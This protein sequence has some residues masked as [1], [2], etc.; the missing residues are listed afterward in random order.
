MSLCHLATLLTVEDLSK[1]HDILIFRIDILKH[2]ISHFKVDAVPERTNTILDAANH[3][4]GLS[5]RER[6]S[7]TQQIVINILSDTFVIQ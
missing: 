2:H 1:L 3:I 6:P 7:H 5:L 4:S